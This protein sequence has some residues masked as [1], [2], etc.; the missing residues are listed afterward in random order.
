MASLHIILSVSSIKLFKKKNYLLLEC[1]GPWPEVGYGEG[2]AGWEGRELVI[3][4]NTLASLIDPL[5]IS[6]QRNR[7]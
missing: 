3:V 4:Y 6:A 1:T 7:Y 5:S 2:F